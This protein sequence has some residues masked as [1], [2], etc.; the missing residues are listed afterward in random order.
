MYLADD[1]EHDNKLNL[2][3]QR[4]RGGKKILK[5]LGLRAYLLGLPKSIS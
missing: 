3:I 1:S 5:N 2:A 4:S